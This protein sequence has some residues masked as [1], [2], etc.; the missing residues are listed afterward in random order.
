MN[1]STILHTTF[2][3]LISVSLLCACGSDE[4]ENISPTPTPTPTPSPTPG[5]DTENLKA[6]Q[7]DM[8]DLEKLNVPTGNYS[9]ITPIGNGEYAVV[10]DKAYGAGFVI[11]ELN[12]NAETGRITGAKRRVPDGTD[13]SYYPNGDFNWNELEAAGIVVNEGEGIVYYKKKN[14]VFI[15]CEEGHQGPRIIEYDL[16]G[17]ATERGM[18]FPEDYLFFTDEKGN[19]QHNWNDGLFDLESLAYSEK[20]GLFWT[21]TE[22]S[23]ISDRKEGD[24]SALCRLISFNEDLSFKD[25][26]FYRTDEYDKGGTPNPNHIWGISEICALDDGRL[27]VMERNFEYPECYI[28]LYVVNP[29]KAK[30]GDLLDKKLVYSNKGTSEA[31]ARIGKYLYNYEGM[32]LGPKLNNGTQTLLLIADSDNI[33]KYIFGESIKVLG[34]E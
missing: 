15:A 11:L 17:K 10:D 29:S 14:S 1:Y 28:S 5:G 6:T 27:I 12:I 31:T 9:G 23:L 32:C 30:S 16:K 13:M 7:L 18:K 20:T 21:T 22:R 8:V 33:N 2:G 24:K 25:Q 34:L 19:K 4:P 3:I 26:Y